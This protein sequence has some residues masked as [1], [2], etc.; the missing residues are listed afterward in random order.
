MFANTKGVDF[1]VSDQ[2]VEVTK[3]KDMTMEDFHDSFN[4]VVGI[5]NKTIDLFDNPYLQFNVYEFIND[6]GAM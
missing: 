2:I 6:K 3:L 1:T 5:K 4:F